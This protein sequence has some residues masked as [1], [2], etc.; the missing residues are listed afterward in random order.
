MILDEV[1]AY[2]ETQG[3]GTVKLPTNDPAWPIHKGGLHPGTVTHPD[4][5]IGLSEGPGDPPINEMGSTVGAVAAEAPS[6][7]VTVRSSSYTT[8]RAKAEA[9]RAKLHKYAGTLSSTRYLLILARHSPFP[10]GRDDKD[11]WL[12]GCNY[13]VTK[14]LS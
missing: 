11:R 8:A 5:A 14:E 6:L 3:L 4:D 9:V 12:I 1:A 10:L 2:L 13:D 7:V